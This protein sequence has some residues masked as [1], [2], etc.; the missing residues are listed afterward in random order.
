MDRLA[1]RL[2]WRSLVRRPLLPVMVVLTM[3]LSIGVAAT[4]F[5]LFYPV[6][7]K[8]LPFANADRIVHLHTYDPVAPENEFGVSLPDYEDFKR[9]TQT[10][11]ALSAHIVFPANFR[12]GSTTKPLQVGF[13]TPEFFA[14]LGAEPILGRVFTSAENVLYGDNR[15]AILSHALWQELF[16]G[17]SGV[18]NRTI[19]LRGEQYQVIGVMPTTFAYPQD[20][21]VWAPIMARYSSFPDRWWDRRDMTMHEVLGRLAPNASA[22]QASADIEAV[23]RE[24]RRLYPDQSGNTHVAVQALRHV[25]LK[26]LRPYV[27]AAG[28]AALLVVIIACLN[29]INLLIAQ[30]L[31]RD[32]EVAVLS[33]LGASAGEL[34]RRLLIESLVVSVTAAGFGVLLATYGT[35]LLASLVPIGLPYW[36]T[37]HVDWRVVAFAVMV[38]LLLALLFPLAPLRHYRKLRFSD[39]LKP[40]GAATGDARGAMRLRQML[41]I[42]QVAISL[43]VVVAASLIGQSVERIMSAET[44]AAT[45]QL[46][47]AR[48]SRYIPNLTLEQESILYGDE[49]M[50]IVERL[51]AMPGVDAVA[52]AD[53]TPFESD[54]PTRAAFKLYTREKATAETAPLLPSQFAFVMP[55][56]FNSLG[57]P[58]KEGREFRE[59]DRFGS[60]HVIVLSEALARTLFPGRSAIGQ[61]VQWGE[62]PEFPWAT[63]I[64]VVGASRWTSEET[65]PSYEFYYTH[66][67]HPTAYP[68]FIVR[69]N[70]DPQALVEPMRQAIKEASP[71]FGV[72]W[73]KPLTVVREE[74]VWRRKLTVWVMKVFGVFALMLSSVGVYGVAAHVVARRKREMSIRMALGS[75]PLALFT[76]ALRDCASTVGLGI[77]VGLLLSFAG[78]RA[79]APLL[80][81]TSPIDPRVL[82]GGVA[83]I[84]GVAF[85]AALGPTIRVLQLT[86]MRTLREE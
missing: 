76:L 39:V 23:M 25:E 22:T 52:F 56:F 37:L 51:K 68:R 63:V 13:T 57:I 81:N 29:V 65:G 30:A 80:W 71:E 5:P 83:L 46:V 86:P 27:L 75:S 70:G 35:R 78:S 24:T 49:W 62:D 12:W 72:Q 21:E 54:Y 50:R 58:I 84:V 79:I 48:G 19:E 28:V 82:L 40:G 2:A 60:P 36:L 34:V 44:G 17:D 67:Q 61:E 53:K 32:R 59:S 55:G 77:L 42:A 16:T 14:I 41:L 64:G 1:T 26:T 4:I 8:P 18:V 7:I 45:T 10:F 66:R 31:T 33:A 43:I 3:A 69:T 15:K 11:T 85:V 38:A 73:I 74:G 6:F 20:A 47:A 9:Q